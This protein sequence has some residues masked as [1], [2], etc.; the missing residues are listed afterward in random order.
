[1]DREESRSVSTKY[2]EE[3]AALVQVVWWN[4]ALRFEENGEGDKASM[5]EIPEALDDFLEFKC[6]KCGACCKRVDIMAPELDRGDRI[7]K[8]LKEDNTCWIYHKRPKVCRITALMLKKPT[9][10]ATA[11]QR[12]RELYND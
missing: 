2:S 1:M 7:C 5:E 10:L 4:L 9:L 8:H 12:L 6:I 11:C 3:V